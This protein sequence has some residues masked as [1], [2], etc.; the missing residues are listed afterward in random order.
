[1]CTSLTNNCT[2]ATLSFSNYNLHFNFSTAPEL[3]NVLTYLAAPG[4]FFVKMLHMLTPTSKVGVGWAG[5][6]FEKK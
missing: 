5:L 3:Q 2:S 1:M 4:A 6:N